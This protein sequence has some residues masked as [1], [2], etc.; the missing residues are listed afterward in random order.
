[1]AIEPQEAALLLKELGMTDVLKEQLTAQK[2]LEKRVFKTADGKEMKF[3][4]V[5]SGRA[6]DRIKVK[7]SEL[8]L[9]SMK[10]EQEIRSKIKEIA[11]ERPLTE[12]FVSEI[13][14]SEKIPAQDLDNYY[15]DKLFDKAEAVRFIIKEMFQVEVEDE[16]LME[17][18]GAEMER[19]AVFFC[20]KIGI[21]L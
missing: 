6:A 8:K 14:T 20:S 4:S 17:Q 5:I 21:Q 1:M 13:Y 10:K 3:K 2:D 15:S 11:G 19:F 18:D 7:L 16:W 12:V 9:D